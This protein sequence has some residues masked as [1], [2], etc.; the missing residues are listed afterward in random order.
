[1]AGWTKEELAAIAKD[2]NL[3]ISI[4]NEDGSMHKP[5]W[6]WIAQAGEDLYA[7]GYSGTSSRW[8]QAARKMG[9][10]HISVG[11][12]EKDVT[13][14]FPEDKATNDAVDEGY[15]SKY[16]GSQYLAPMIDDSSRIATVKLVPTE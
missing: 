9:H 8:Y 4:P 6:V 12:V 14:E 16:A 5:A 2:E 3:Y 13:F 10:G 7:R 11:G 15:K 1:M